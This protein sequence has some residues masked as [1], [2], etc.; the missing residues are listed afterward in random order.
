MFEKIEQ[1]SSNEFCLKMYGYKI[2]EQDLESL[3]PYSWV[4]DNV[5]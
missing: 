1:N 4:N 2:T 3:N 5:N